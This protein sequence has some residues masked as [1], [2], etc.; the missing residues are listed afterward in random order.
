MRHTASPAVD[1]KPELALRVFR[2]E[3]NFTR[4]CVHAFSVND[5]MVNQFLHFH[6]DLRF[7]RGQIFWVLYH[8][9]SLGQFLDYLT[10]DMDTL[11]HLF[12]SYEIAVVGVTDSTDRDIKLVLLVIK[13]GI[14]FSNVVVN[15]AS[16]NVWTGQAIRNCVFLRNHAEISGAIHPDAVTRQEL[17]E[18]V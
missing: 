5:E 1:V 6:Q 2:T 12:K 15:S 3:I 14:G 11:T 4:R 16:A 10:Q 8:D 18:L 7:I 9:R 13:V 17:V